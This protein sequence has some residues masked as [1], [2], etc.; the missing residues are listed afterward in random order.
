MSGRQHLLC[1]RPAQLPPRQAR[2]PLR[3]ETHLQRTLCA[4]RETGCR[5]GVAFNPSTDPACLRWLADDVDLVLLMSVNPGFGGQQFIPGTLRKVAQ[6]RRLIAD[7]GSKAVI[8]V[9]GGVNDITGLQL[10]Q[11]GADI[12]VAGNYVFKAPNPLEAIAKLKNL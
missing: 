9:D 2:L 8:E 5:A 4:I 1:T 6:L 10:A 11:A 3:P 7:T 12:L